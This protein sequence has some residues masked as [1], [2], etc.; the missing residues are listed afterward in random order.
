MHYNL[1]L[2]S[3]WEYDNGFIRLLDSACLA[4]GRSLLTV[5]PA[6]LA[7]VLPLLS[8]GEAG[9]SALLDRA[10][11]SD[12]AFLPLVDIAKASGARRFNPRELADRAYDKASMHYKF[13]EAGINT[14]HTIILPSYIAQ[15]NLPDLD[16]SPLGEKFAVKPALGGGGEGV[17]TE[18]TRL[19]EVLSERMKFPDQQYLLQSHVA[20]KMLDGYP[21]WFR[22]IYC[23]GDFHPSFWDVKTHVYTVLQ[24][25]SQTYSNLR[26]VT[27]RIV[28]I[29]ELDLF[30]SEI[31][32]SVD[33][34]LLVV[35]YVNDP[36]D[37]RLQSL[38]ADGVPDKIVHDIVNRL[39]SV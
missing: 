28:E 29:C 17:S 32:L 13:I 30:S 11:E 36:I 22:V 19:E 23:M 39:V 26:V 6:N 21:A 2:A 25:D 38:A 34:Q 5:T 8:S 27:T 20:P 31:A 37:L 10:S 14:P 18:V 12:P 3:N 33:E 15:P 1:C 7:D 35:D 4:R 9:F 24:P 16:L